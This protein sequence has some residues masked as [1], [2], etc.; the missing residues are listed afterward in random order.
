MARKPG[1]N[2]VLREVWRGRVWSAR[3]VTVVRDD[4]AAIALYIP[5]GTTWLRPR[6]LDDQVLRIP[7]QPWVVRPAVWENNVLRISPPGEDYSVMLVWDERWRLQFW[8]VNVEERVRPGPFGYDYMD[9]ALDAV[10]SPDMGE[11]RWKDEDE[12]AECLGRGIFPQEMEAR[13]RH[14]GQAALDRLLQRRA[15][16]NEPWEDWRPDPAWAPPVLPAEWEQDTLA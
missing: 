8:Y 1:A 6:T 7:D 4:G 16:F 3:P 10:V 12:L 15:P 5:A 9:W 14:A 2:V 13:I 11:W